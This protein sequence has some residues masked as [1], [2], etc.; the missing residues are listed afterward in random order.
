[1]CV[2]VH[3][4][5][6]DIEDGRVVHRSVWIIMF[7]LIKDLMKANRAVLP[8]DFVVHDVRETDHLS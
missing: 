2:S 7:I 3:T 1:M 4:L 6:E 5:C 8:H